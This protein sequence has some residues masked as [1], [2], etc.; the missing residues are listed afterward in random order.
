MS[1][2]RSIAPPQC[3]ANPS[4]ETVISSL[5]APTSLSKWT[6]L[7]VVS[8]IW[9]IRGTNLF[10]NTSRSG[11]DWICVS[12]SLAF[13]RWRC[14]WFSRS[15]SYCLCLQSV[16]SFLMFK[17]SFLSNISLYWHRV[18]WHAL[19]KFLVFTSKPLFVPGTSSSSWWSWASKTVSFAHVVPD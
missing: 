3:N 13:E 2:F 10:A 5:L 4:Q 12:C 6:H 19:I 14:K 15:S 17:R 9:L 7:L 11:S 8:L 1:F 18:S 16:S